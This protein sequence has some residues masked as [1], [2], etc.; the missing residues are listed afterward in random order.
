MALQEQTMKLADG[1][2]LGYA[3][4]GDL[5]GSVVFL[6]HGFCGSRLDGKALDATARSAHVRLIVPDRPGFGLSDPQVTRTFADWPRD[7]LELALHVHVDQFSVLGVGGGAPYVI[8]CSARIAEHVRSAGVVSGLS[9]LTA[10]ILSAMSPEK[11]SLFNSGGRYS[12]IARR[13]LRRELSSRRPRS[14]SSQEGP[15]QQQSVP[16]AFRQGIEGAVHELHLYRRPWGFAVDAVPLPVLLWHG[17]MDTEMPPA[18]AIALADMLPRTIT[19]WYGHEG[20]ALLPAHVED[21]LKAL[22]A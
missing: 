8:A 21:I 3:E 20:S 17:R 15:V 14:G 7:V 16:E 18:M 22:I 11:R 5:G 10:E 9:P 1:R 19:R 13:V 4:Y 6:F 2:R 12:W